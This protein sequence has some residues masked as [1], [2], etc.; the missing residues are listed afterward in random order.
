MRAVGRGREL[1][2]VEIKCFCVNLAFLAESGCAIAMQRSS[3]G[4]KHNFA[5]FLAVHSPKL[6]NR[7]C[8]SIKHDPFW[9][10]SASQWASVNRGSVVAHCGGGEY[11]G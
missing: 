3:Q 4:M 1:F 8:S 7:G 11:S 9:G 6:S 5:H 2:G 10:P